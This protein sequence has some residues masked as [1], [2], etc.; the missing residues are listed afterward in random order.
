[1]FAE[2]GEG[3]IG[4]NAPLLQLDQSSE[5]NGNKPVPL[6]G[7]GWVKQGLQELVEELSEGAGSAPI[8]PSS[9]PCFI[10]EMGIVAP[11]CAQKAALDRSAREGA[12]TSDPLALFSE[13]AVYAEEQ[14]FSRAAS[15]EDFVKKG[16]R[17]SAALIYNHY[18]MHELDPRLGAANE[19][20]AARAF[21]K[22]LF[23]TAINE[24]PS[25]EM[26]RPEVDTIRML[27][28]LARVESDAFSRMN[29]T[30]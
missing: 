29:K 21:K 26:L 4:A 17:C 13:M 6:P 23:E 28:M 27:Q 20:R 3:P 12:T 22:V 10:C 18:F 2:P 15:D 9:I 25:G 16:F 30:T 14:I 1:M 7:F 19:V 5:F 24:S 8:D 11:T